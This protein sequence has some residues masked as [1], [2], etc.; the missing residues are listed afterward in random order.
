M[1]SAHHGYSF[2]AKADGRRGGQ[3]RA[4]FPNSN[5]TDQFPQTVV[6]QMMALYSQNQ[7]SCNC[8]NEASYHN[9]WKTQV[10]L[11][12][13][14]IGSSSP[15]KNYKGI[16]GIWCFQRQVRLAIKW[17]LFILYKER[18]SRMQGKKSKSSQIKI[19]VSCQVL[20]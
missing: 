14:C 11:R 8:C 18:I 19:H 13:S 20:D 1:G 6:V 17:V 16:N 2:Q 5:E 9:L 10:A 3:N 12:L 7:G 15:S 4:G